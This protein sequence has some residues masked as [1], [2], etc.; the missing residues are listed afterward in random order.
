MIKNI[1]ININFKNMCKKC[2][3]CNTAKD[4]LIRINLM[5]L[6]EFDKIIKEGNKFDKI[7]S[8]REILSKPEKNKS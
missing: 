1:Q 5:D 8:R 4:D 7:I 3:I 2:V 6:N